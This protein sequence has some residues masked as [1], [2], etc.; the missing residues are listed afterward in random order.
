[1]SNKI[2]SPFASQLA[3]GTPSPSAHANQFNVEPF[4]SH[5]NEGFPH[6]IFQEG[7]DA[8]LGKISSPMGEMK[9]GSKK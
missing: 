6:V 1:M 3:K 9:G 4:S 2:N 5:P 7:L 8:K